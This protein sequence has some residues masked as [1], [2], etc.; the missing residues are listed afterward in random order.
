MDCLPNMQQDSA[1]SVYNATVAVLRQLRAAYGPAVPLLVLEGH[2]Y[3]N[4]WIKPQQAANEDGLCATQRTAFESLQSEVPNLHYAGSSGKLGPDA[5]VASESTGGI[6][7]HPSQL[8][9]LHMAQFAADKLR[10]L[11]G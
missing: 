4:N 10:A 3:T 8:A 1:A 6:G 11:W 2:E 7:V 9:H 5:D